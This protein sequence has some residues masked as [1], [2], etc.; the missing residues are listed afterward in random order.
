MV[1]LVNYTPGPG[2]REAHTFSHIKPRIFVLGIGRV[3]IAKSRHSAEG[4]GTA[5]PFGASTET[6]DDGRGLVS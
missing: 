6:L 4:L 5:V 2:G 3:G 1:E